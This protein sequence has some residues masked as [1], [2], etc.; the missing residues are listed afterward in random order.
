VYLE[1]ASLTKRTERL[2]ERIDESGD[3]ITKF[4]AAAHAE[5]DGLLSVL[6]RVLRK[7]SLRLLA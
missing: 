1:I 5:I 6:E 2:L 7:M 4:Q 3:V